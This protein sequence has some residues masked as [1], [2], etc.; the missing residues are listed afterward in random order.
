MTPEQAQLLES[1]IGLL[2]QTASATSMAVLLLLLRRKHRGRTFFH[3]W[4]MAWLS[5]SIALMSLV[6]SS[7]AWVTA[8]EMTTV[9]WQELFYAIYFLGKFGFYLL[10]VAGTLRFTRSETKRARLAFHITA[11]VALL[12]AAALP[13]FQHNLTTLVRAQAPAACVA[14]LLCAHLFWRQHNLRSFGT[15][16]CT[17]MFLAMSALW[18]T[19]FMVLSFNDVA[20]LLR[21]SSLY[22]ALTHYNSYFDLLVQQLLAFGFVVLL[23][24]QGR[25][26]TDL[27]HVKLLAAHEKLRNVALQ[28]QLTGAENRLALREYQRDELDK[29]ALVACDLDL[30]KDVNDQFG[31]EAGDQLLSHFVAVLREGLRD[32]DRIFRMGG[33][34][35]VLIMPTS[36]PAD[37]LHRVRTLL[38]QAPTSTWREHT[39][40]LT[41]SLGAVNWSKGADLQTTLHEAD[42]LMYAD[43]RSNK[44]TR[45]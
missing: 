6:V 13:C 44:A 15:R 11:V 5:L 8:G 41:A 39:L 4:C 10:L 14:G 35:F 38:Q 18:F 26:E 28:D 24:E 40:R 34:E 20:G 9:T 17:L 32:Y 19:Y 43:K 27:A 25:R 16:Y 33:D 30:L 37:A 31:H 21:G 36:D 29:C 7:S 42:Q 2:A 3:L 22:G 23:L 12:F 1:Q 45:R